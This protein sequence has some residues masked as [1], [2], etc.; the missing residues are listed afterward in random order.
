MKYRIDLHTHTNHSDGTFSPKKLL[1]EAK[2]K[3][4][5]AIA[6][7]D[8]DTL[9]G[10]KEILNYKITE[11]EVIPG[12]EI[13]VKSEEERNLVEVHMLGY[14]INCND[15]KFLNVLDKLN[16]AKITWLYNQVKVLNEAGF[17][18][19]V[20][21][22]KKIAGTAV[23][24][25][26]HVFKVIEKNNP[27]KISREDFFKRTSFG[28]DLYVKRKFELKLEECIKLIKKADGIPV[29]AHP[30]FYDMESV[31]KTAIDAGVCGLEVKYFYNNFGKKRSKEIERY[32]SK[33]TE[34]HGLLK[35]G[36]SD[37]HGNEGGAELGSVYVPY[38]FLEELKKFKNNF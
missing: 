18:I 12:I 13:G 1:T 2:K 25:R 21:E 34:K 11:I 27:G 29:L 7:T 16:E 32:L 33:L 31:V 23:P 37:F 10:F 30:G 38:K 28:G 35:T 22:V 14:L 17:K 8:H 20:K 15:K 5:K 24:R 36:G 6:I 26:P 3:G 4:L 19:T 9:S